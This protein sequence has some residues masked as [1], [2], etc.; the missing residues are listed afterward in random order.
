MQI[1]T[2][3]L[4]KW[5]L[6]CFMKFLIN[7]CVYWCI[8]LTF[9]NFQFL[10]CMVV[11]YQT[12]EIYL[13]SI[14]R[15]FNIRIALDNCTIVQ[16]CNLS[17]ICQLILNFFNNGVVNILFYNKQYQTIL[18]CGIENRNKKVSIKSRATINWC[19]KIFPNFIR[20]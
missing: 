8:F 11:K 12:L 4:W 15:Q 19:L 3:F 20:K 17:L 1:K 10:F 2:C 7:F 13:E 6:F 18:K 16:W 5:K 9:D 14:N